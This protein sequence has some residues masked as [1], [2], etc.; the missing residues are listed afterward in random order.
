MYKLIRKKFHDST[1]LER[2][3]DS[4]TF[5]DK[6]SALEGMKKQEECYDKGMKDANKDKKAIVKIKTDTTIIYAYNHTEKPLVTLE[7][8][9]EE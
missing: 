8:E 7:L 2:K 1:W 4:I 6:E 9:E 5:Q 3:V